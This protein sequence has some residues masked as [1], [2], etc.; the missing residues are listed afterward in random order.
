MNDYFFKTIEIYG[1][2]LYVYTKSKPQGNQNPC[3]HV[4]LRC[5]QTYYLFNLQC[6]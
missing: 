3:K 5:L 6:T 2:I 1:Q 4:N